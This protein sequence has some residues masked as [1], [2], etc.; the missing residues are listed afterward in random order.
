MMIVLLVV[1][2]VAAIAILGRKHANASLPAV[3]A[4]ALCCC[5]SL[6]IYFCASAFPRADGLI[7]AGVGGV[8][9]SAGVYALVNALCLRRAALHDAASRAAGPRQPL[10]EFVEP[11]EEEHERKTGE[12][13]ESDPDDILTEA[14]EKVELPKLW[15]ED[16]PESEPERHAFDEALDKALF[17]ETEDAAET[18]DV[19]AEAEPET[20]GIAAEAE[21]EENTV[22]EPFVASVEVLEPEAET[23]AETEESFVQTDEFVPAGFE[24]A[25]EISED[26]EPKQEPLTEEEEETG[27]PPLVLEETAETGEAAED[28]EPDLFSEARESGIPPLMLGETAADAEQGLPA[29]EE[30]SDIPPLALKEI[31]ED[32]TFVEEP[33]FLPP[34]E[35]ENGE[36]LEKEAEE[37]VEPAEAAEGETETV[38]FD[39]ARF[40][41]FVEEKTEADEAEATVPIELAAPVEETETAMP[42]AFGP[43]EANADS[44]GQNTEKEAGAVEFD[45]AE[46]FRFVGEEPE[47]TEPETTEPAEPLKEEPATIKPMPKDIFEFVEEDEGT[48]EPEA[49]ERAE[50]YA[51]AAAEDIA[52]DAESFEEAFE[53]IEFEMP[54]SAVDKEEAEAAESKSVT[55]PIQEFVAAVVEKFKGIEPEP[56][57]EEAFAEFEPVEISESAGPEPIYEEAV[58]EPAGKELSAAPVEEEPEAGPIETTEE[59]KPAEP[60]FVPA[61]RPAFKPV[62]AP[63]DFAR[64]KDEAMAEVKA[65]VAKRQYNDALTSLFALLNSGFAL[66][67]DEKRQLLIIMKLLK[68]KGI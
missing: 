57:R 4:L 50:I 62:P 43:A 42:E 56:I 48:A 25:G 47:T 68:E 2:G 13:Q 40:F 34:L 24:E 15:E 35:E 41:K 31:A 17:A 5:M 66:S 49:I 19:I 32:Y 52:E 8:L 46:F 6:G 36:P 63:D 20:E 18:E 65:L 1:I 54:E 39:A 37:T 27:I 67:E 51:K 53:A 33:D 3:L 12:G 9:L 45:V 11:D 64:R 21:T 10:V 26:A 22:P 16:A 14:G 44:D 28:A 60:A 29:Q 38:E 58:A 7:F 30:E 59:P 23:E 61:E 55:A